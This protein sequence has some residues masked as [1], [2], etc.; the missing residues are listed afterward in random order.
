MVGLL[1]LAHCVETAKVF[2]NYED[3]QCK[4]VGKDFSAFVHTKTAKPFG[5]CRDC[6]GLCDMVETFEVGEMYG[7]CIG[8]QGI[9]R[10]QRWQKIGRDSLAFYCIGTAWVRKPY[11]D[12]MRSR[13]MCGDF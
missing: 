7:D 2:C 10:L 1:R 6:I 5:N 3:C 13:V 12:S 9:R 11:R 4:R 8:S